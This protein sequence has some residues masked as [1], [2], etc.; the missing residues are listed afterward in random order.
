MLQGKLYSRTG[1]NDSYIASENWIAKEYLYAFIFGDVLFK[2]QKG[3]REFCYGYTSKLI[4]SAKL[5]CLAGNCIVFCQGFNCVKFVSVYLKE[6]RVKKNVV[7]LTTG[8]R[9]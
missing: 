8:S 9:K 4:R 1:Y 7:V 5:K 2:T 3:N 6:P